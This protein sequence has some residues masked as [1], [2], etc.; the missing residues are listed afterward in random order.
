MMNGQN[1][2]QTTII[3]I[4]FIG[5]LTR[6]VHAGDTVPGITIAFLPCSHLFA[7]FKKFNPLISYLQRE[8][9]MALS[10][11]VPADFEEFEQGIKSGNIAFALQDPNIYLRSSKWFD[12]KHL[13]G[14]FTNSGQTHQAGAVIVRRDS[15]IKDLKDLKGKSV[16]FGPK[17]SASKWLAAKALF[18]ANGIDLDKHLKSYS[19]GKCCEDIAFSV[20]LKTVDAG[21][22]CD[23]FLGGHFKKQRE[24]GI[25]A[26][27]I[28]VLA[29]TQP[30]PTKVF[31]SRK[32]VQ[33]NIIAEVVRA[34]L[35][36]DNSNP[37]DKKIL[38]SAEV[39][40]F[41]ISRQETYSAM[42]GLVDE[43]AME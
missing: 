16:L 9:G 5:L 4:L 17:L 32:D 39:G 11:K 8:T 27:E 6:P 26:E 35:K 43:T 14:T 19:N 3:V 29:R 28:Q 24:L 34:L 31:A 10:L 38:D 2:R 40:G 21:V 33:A 15:G 36:L 18:E 25:K 23:H 22:V 12:N 7:S 42:K 30:V 37:A 13:V 41:F 1:K 20:Y